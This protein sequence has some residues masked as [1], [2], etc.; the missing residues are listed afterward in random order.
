MQLLSSG[1]K[2]NFTWNTVSKL[3]QKLSK[4]ERGFGSAGLKL[5]LPPK[6]CIPSRAKI[7]MNKNRS[8]KSE[9]IDW[10]ELRSDATRFESDRQ[11]LW[12]RKYFSG[13]F[14][15]KL[16]SVRFM[17]PLL[18]FLNNSLC[19]FEDPQQANAAQHRNSQRRHDVRVEQNHLADASNHHEAVESVEQRYEVAL[20]AQAV[21]LE[22]HLHGE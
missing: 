1:C 6:T 14:I 19:D 15:R 18:R 16:L 20:K 12:M 8:S 17:S 4:F 7:T 13:E 3:C 21:H 5:N 11:Y 22:E 2:V 9:A 10:I